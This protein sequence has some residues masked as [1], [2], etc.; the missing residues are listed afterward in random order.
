MR[1]ENKLIENLVFGRSG[2]N[3][4]VFEKLFISYSCI[5]FIKYYTLRSFC[6]KLLYFSKNCVFHIFNLSNLFLDQ[7]KMRLKF[8]FESVWFDCCSIASGL[9]E[10]NFR[11]IE[12]N[13][14]SIEN[15]IESFLKPWVFTCSITIQTFSKVLSLSLRSVKAQSTFFCCFP[16]NFF[17]V[18]DF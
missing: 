11:S 5:L 15:R 16:S 14:W 6:I 4:R 17:E 12:S 7:S 3:S 2:L 10:C 1:F 13:F 9:I 18:F 8:C